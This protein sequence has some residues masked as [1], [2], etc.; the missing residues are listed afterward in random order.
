MTIGAALLKT[1]HPA[2]PQIRRKSWNSI[3]ISHCNE[4]LSIHSGPNDPLG[5]WWTPSVE[6]LTAKDW[7]PGWKS[8]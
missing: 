2:K 8:V 4:S 3:F 6:D 5:R 1:K 7:E